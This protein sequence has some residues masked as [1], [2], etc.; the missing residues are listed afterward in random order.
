[1]TKNPLKPPLIP[2][3]LLRLMKDYMIFYSIDKDL[4]EVYQSIV[5]SRGQLRA[6][7]WYWHQSLGSLPKYIKLA[8]YWRAAM[9]GNYLKSALR[10]I[11]KHKGFSFINISGLAVGMACCILILMY[12][13]DELSYDRFHTKADHIYRVTFSSD[14]DGLPTNANGSFGVGPTLKKDFPEILETIRIRR[15]GQDVKRYVGYGENKFYE[16]RFFFA[17][18]SFLTVFDFPLIKGNPETALNEPNTIVLTEEMAVKYFGKKDPIGKTIE[19]DP[20]NDGEI[21]AAFSEGDGNP[22]ILVVGDFEQDI[23]EAIDRTDVFIEG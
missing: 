12:V 3:L 18:P 22:E 5:R 1:M 14:D 11:T 23:V 17:E 19:A 2:R 4:N 16:T 15:M 10:N 7:L 21:L 9:F 6:V 13:T 8:V 20:Y